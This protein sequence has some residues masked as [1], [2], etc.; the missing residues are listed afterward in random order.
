[1][2]NLRTTTA[3]PPL[4]RE[5]AIKPARVEWFF[6]LTL[7]WL[8]PERL[9]EPFEPR[10]FAMRMQRLRSDLESML[11]VIGYSE[12]DARRVS[13]IFFEGIEELRHALRRDA[14]RIVADD[15]TQG[16]LAG[17]LRHSQ[18][19]RVRAADTI[20]HELAKLHVPILPFVIARRT[21]RRTGLPV[22]FGRD[23][24]PAS[25]TTSPSVIETL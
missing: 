12:S 10:L 14:V 3:L 25:N 19:F 20:A 4:P 8:F 1:M 11:G 21:E 24:Q 2:T 5:L 15:P 17:V 16:S 7:D 6:S 18:V 22:A 13:A 23:V 9:G